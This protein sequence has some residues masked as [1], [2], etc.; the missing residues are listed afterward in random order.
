MSSPPPDNILTDPSSE[1]HAAL[2]SH[3]FGLDPSSAVLEE[4]CFPRTAEDMAAVAAEARG[5]KTTPSSVVGRA[6]LVFLG[7][8]GEAVVELSGKGFTVSCDWMR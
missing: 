6:R 3:A 7:D 2:K 8:E 4:T 5:S 1:L